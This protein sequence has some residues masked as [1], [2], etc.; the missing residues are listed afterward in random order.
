MLI[1][2]HHSPAEVWR[3]LTHE[4]R[5]AA[6]ERKHP[7]WQFVLSTSGPEGAE[8]CYVVLRRWS[9]DQELLFYTDGRSA[10]V[11]QMRAQPLC[12]AVF[13]HPR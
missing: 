4:L 7:L 1:K 9:P 2:P 3:D 13:Y 12:C 8:A 10:K 6:R 5:R 11:Q